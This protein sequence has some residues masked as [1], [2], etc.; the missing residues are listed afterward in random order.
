[1]TESNQPRSRSWRSVGWIVLILVLL[2]LL[3]VVVLETAL[4][5]AGVQQAIIKRLT[6]EVATRSGLQLEIDDL[7]LSLVRATVRVGR[8]RLS[9]PGGEPLFMT[10][11]LE[12]ALKL[13]SLWNP[14]LTLRK[15]VI[16]EPQLDLEQELPTIPSAAEGAAEGKE[17]EFALLVE[18]F[19]LDGGRV[20]GPV[21][22]RELE[23]WIE[24]WWLEDVEIQ[25]RFGALDLELSFGTKARWRRSDGEEVEVGIEGEIEG[26]QV[27][28]W[29]LSHLTLDGQGVQGELEGV[30]GI[31]PAEPLEARFDLTLEPHRLVPVPAATEPIRLSG[32]FDTRQRTGSFNLSMKGLP[33]ELVS[34]WL[35]EE[36]RLGEQTR[37]WRL[38]ADVTGSSG[39]PDS[40]TRGVAEL[41]LLRHDKTWLIGEVELLPNVESTGVAARIELSLLPDQRGQRWVRGV[42]SAPD[43]TQFADA[44]LRDGELAIVDTDLGSVFRDLETLWPDLLPEGLDRSVFGSLEAAGRAEGPVSALRVELESSWAHGDF[45]H[46]HARATGTPQQSIVDVDFEV[47]RLVLSRMSSEIRGEATAR[48]SAQLRP[49]GYLWRALVSGSDLGA[50]SAELTVDNL[51]LELSGSNRQVV[52]ETLSGLLDGH[53]FQG[54]G[55]LGLP[56]SIGQAEMSLALE[57]P[58]SGLARVE[59]SLSLEEGELIAAVEPQT[60]SGVASRFDAVLPWATLE[61]LPQLAGALSG[62]PVLGKK[63]PLRFR[64]EIPEA[65]W[66]DLAS[67]V[68][69]QANLTSLW[70]GSQGSLVLDP[71]RP[72]AGSGEVV[73]DAL[74][75]ET[76]EVA[77]AARKSMRIRLDRGELIVEET[78]LETAGGEIEVE[79]WSELNEDWQPG[80]A[81]QAALRRFEIE[82]RGMVPIAL[83]ETFLDGAKADGD[84]QLA[85]EVSGSTEE[86]AGELRLLGSNAHLTLDGADGVS[87]SDPALVVVFDGDRLRVE[88]ARLRID[89]SEIEAS[90]EIPLA[91]LFG[92]LDSDRRDSRRSLEPPVVDWR[93]PEADLAPTLRRLGVDE[94]LDLA[95]VGA[96]GQLRVDPTRLMEASGWIEISPL[97]LKTGGREVRGDG[98][99]RLDLSDGWLE[100]TSIHLITDD[101]PLALVGGIQLDRGWHPGTQVVSLIESL[102]L[103]GRG[104]LEAALLN[105]FLAGGA[106]EGLLELDFDISGPLEELEGRILIE[107]PD[108]SVLFIS[109]Y[110]AKIEAPE[111]D[112]HLVDGRANIHDGRVVVNDGDVEL[113][114]SLGLDGIDLTAAFDGLRFRLDYGLLT[115]IDGDLELTLD[116][117]S[118]GRLS[119]ELIVDQGSLTRSI[120]IDRDLISELLSP[121]DLTGTEASLLE[122]IELDLSLETRRGIRV[123]NSV[124]DLAIQWNAVQVRGTVAQ[125]VIDGRFE[126]EPGGRVF[127][128]GQTLRVDRGVVSYPGQ[129]GAAAILDLETTNSIDDPSINRLQGDDKLVMAPP[130]QTDDLETRARDVG[131]STAAFVSEQVAARITEVVPGARL[132]FRPI[133]IFGEADPGARLTVGREF[134]RYVVL[135]ASIDLRN[136]ERQTFL[137]DAHDLPG[138][139]GLVLQIFTNDREQDGAT[140]QHR[141][142]FG[143]YRRTAPTGPRLRRL[144]IQEVPEISRRSLHRAAGLEKGDRA[145]ADDLFLAE[146]EIGE[147]LRRS[148]YP[149]ARVDL[150]SSP[151]LDKPEKVDLQVSIEP[152]PWVRFEFT[153]EELPRN[154]RRTI[155]SL[156]RS[157]FYEPAAVEEMKAQAVRALRS[158][159][160][161]RP[162]VEIEVE[163]TIGVEGRPERLVTIWMEGGEQLTLDT[164]VVEGLT[165]EDANQVSSGFATA[166][167]RI[168]LA[169][170]EAAA[171][172]RLLSSIQALGYPK[173]KIIGRHLSD[174]G[175]VLTIGV[176]PGPERRLQA[177]TTVGVDPELATE[178]SQVAE[179]EA[180][181]LARRDRIAS[182]AL[183]I[184]STLQSKGFV[185]AR[186]TPRLEG[187]DDANDTPTVLVYEVESGSGY[188][189]AGTQISGLKSTNKRWATSVAEIEG[190]APL[191]ESE[192]AAARSRLYETGLFTMVSSDSV[193]TEG[194]RAEVVFDVEERPRYSVAYGLRWDDEQGTQGVI[195]VIDGNFLGRNVTLGLRGLYKQDDWSVR[196]AAG[197]PRLFGTRALLELF[198]SYRDVFDELSTE[199]TTTQFDEQIVEN[200][201]QLA[202]PF[203]RNVL[204]R[205]YGRYRTDDL[206]VL[207]ID[208]DPIFPLPPTSL[209]FNF[210]TPL[211][212]TLWTYDSRDS[213]LVLTR[214]LFASLDLSGTGEFLNSDFKYV[215]MFSQVNL[216]L[217]IGRWAGRSLN[218]AQSYRVGLADSFDQELDRNDRF[219]AGGQY[220]VRGY[221]TE[222]L[223]S[224]EELGDLT[225][226]LG[227]KA[228]LVINQELRFELLGPVAGVAFLDLG[229]VWEDV[230]EVDTDLFKSLGIG[231]RAI[232][233]VGLLR[234]DWAFPLD[235][236]QGDPSSKV[237]F[238]FGN[239]F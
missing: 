43:P 181:D 166:L 125:P 65:E 209:E 35:S 176:E 229:N 33:G 8:L 74:R 93:I 101:Q 12:A 225:F 203:G 220:S 109:P 237:Y 238:G 122:E 128:F 187:V 182:G 191:R 5:Q 159:G 142:R 200:S 79:I 179:I 160:Y 233:P 235:R 208:E 183:A 218:W 49:E 145:S 46:A 52:I 71:L 56:L 97:S 62:V 91:T 13:S 137:M 102:E 239:T 36:F 21:V 136:A 18:H 226:P 44:R 168:E 68:T 94:S 55:R 85:L 162:E 114:G 158:L 180:G 14:P 87:L 154:L 106:A 67:L 143:S 88:G 234:L 161:V 210:K 174:D 178:L 157:D 130:E 57:Q 63:G 78:G 134:S 50:G 144:E 59:L 133:L 41:R 153:G 213:E 129:P 207:E 77:V 105:P 152:G 30:A 10:S 89:D 26:P 2:P 177:V 20:D 110:V 31:A 169:A 116:P 236:R 123:R 219:F 115:R 121:I 228:L 11:E 86:V 16:T 199:F 60:T 186:V 99:L 232:T 6:N 72:L 40:A 98:V 80:E 147:F 3:A 64:W 37:D 149:D 127:L 24:H 165:E 184:E 69:E 231:I 111:L 172:R 212:G 54:R 4:H 83:V 32:E 151:V 19:E 17:T 96:Q 45:V 39:G 51:D 95:R 29:N 117:E 204:G 163:A 90:A 108:A 138:L 104:T 34:P 164:L 75:I 124:A 70:F 9:R 15:L 193:V 198:A 206:L 1:M 27:G 22:P 131:W 146:V 118:S 81:L 132:T 211:L 120:S 185:D 28:P 112:I 190:G 201:I 217:P 224:V 170:G 92:M 107:G 202:Y 214:G 119:G 84:L 188:T 216:Y 76:S 38:D 7:R 139:P 148:G 167:R 103:Q 140:L 82:A 47:D 156:Y 215:R 61:R 42:L 173:P 23:S 73:V 223:G 171:D 155:S 141:L 196:M 113:G 135:A 189:I 197:V 195:D 53:R 66:V 222:S 25:G 126:I 175:R 221:P 227:G 150:E 48:G 205:I 100:L 230:S 194:G 58:L 192:V